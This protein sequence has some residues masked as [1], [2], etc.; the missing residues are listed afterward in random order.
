M[1]QWRKSSHSGAHDNTDCVELAS[2]G[3]EVGI[4]DS[5][6]PEAGYL[7]CEPQALQHLVSRIKLGDL[8]L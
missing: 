6:A 7:S 5:K 3:L 2:I 1:I 8:D 4:R